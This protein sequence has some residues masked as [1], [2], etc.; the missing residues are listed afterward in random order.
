[1]PIR[2]G[3][4]GASFGVRGQLPGFR[5]AG[6]ETTAVCSR[7]EST[8]RA[9]AER[10]G[11]AVWTTDPAALVEREDVDL[12]AV[13]TPPYLHLEH[14]RLALAAGKHVLCEKPF[15]MS[16]AEAQTMVDLADN[17]GVVNAIDHEFRYLAWRSKL[18]Q[19]IEDGSL[20]AITAVHAVDFNTQLANAA[21]PRP[22]WWWKREFGGGVL[23]ATA[24]HWIDSLLWWLGE[25]AE[26]TGHVGAFISEQPT[27]EGSRTRVTADDTAELLVRF[28]SGAVAT[29]QLSG[30]AQHPHRRVSVFGRKGTVVVDEQNRLL[31]AGVGEE[32]REIVPPI[33]ESRGAHAGVSTWIVD[34]VALLAADVA[35]HIERPAEPA[36]HP[37]FRDGLKV[38]Q[39]LDRV[40]ASARI[41][42]GDAQPAS[43]VPA[44]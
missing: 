43:F 26:V 22:E 20:G 36:R 17:A 14:V 35:R 28:S 27:A 5:K 4:I 6:L 38:Q 40:R 18:K 41:G 21:T 16:V 19:L 24:S 3:V 31:F 33:G 42:V 25:P 29:L 34:A 10:E 32:L 9:A 23:G 39:V 30:V 2:V 7:N 11:I 15:A 12:V 8:A 13:A 37:T 44:G 1:M